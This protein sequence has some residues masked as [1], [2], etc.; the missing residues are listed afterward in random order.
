[1]PILLCW[2]IWHDSRS[3]ATRKSRYFNYRSKI[4]IFWDRDFKQKRQYLPWKV[5]FFV[6]LDLL[7]ISNSYL[8]ISVRRTCVIFEYRSKIVICC[9]SDFKQKLKYPP[10]TGLF[11]VFLH[12]SRMSNSYLAISEFIDFRL[13]FS[14]EDKDLWV[15]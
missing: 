8:A 3:S 4:V 2:D 6:F 7:R 14:H 13:D 1:M 15:T 5:L 12:W 11:F 9:H 10:L